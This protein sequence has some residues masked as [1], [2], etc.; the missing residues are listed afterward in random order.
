MG[1]FR[2]L[3]LVIQETHTATMSAI[4]RE[5]IV[6]TTACVAGGFLAWLYFSNNKKLRLVDTPTASPAGGHYSQAV[7]RWLSLRVRF[8]T[9]DSDGRKAEQR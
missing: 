2:S 3:V 9:S 5:V 7:I 8:T 4:A 1:L 6:A